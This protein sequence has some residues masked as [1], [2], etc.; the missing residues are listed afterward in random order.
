MWLTA[1]SS[2]SQT[3]EKTLTRSL[4]QYNDGN[5]NDGNYYDRVVWQASAADAQSQQSQ[6]FWRAAD[7]AGEKS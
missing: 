2:L 6:H 7:T 1:S 5:Y 3:G 4:R